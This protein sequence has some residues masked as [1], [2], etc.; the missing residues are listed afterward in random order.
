MLGCTHFPV[1]TEA[2]RA[3]LPP[4]VRIV[5]SAATTAAAVLRQLHGPEEPAAAP[6]PPAAAATLAPRAPQSSRPAGPRGA[7]HGIPRLNPPR[8]AG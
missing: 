3:V 1:L 8:E 6:A 4:Q 7:I 2:I 5:D